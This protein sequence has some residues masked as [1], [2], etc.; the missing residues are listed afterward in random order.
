MITKISTYRLIKDVIETEHKL[1][2]GLIM[3]QDINNSKQHIQQ[4]FPF[5]C[6]EA[7]EISNNKIKI[8]VNNDNGE[9]DINII[10][11]FLLLTNN[12][13]YYIAR[14]KLISNSNINW[15]KMDL[16]KFKEKYYDSNFLKNIIR[17]N[18]LIEPKFD[19]KHK[20][21]TNIL[22]H[23]TENRYLDR[24]F[25]SGL[26]PKSKN[27]LLNYPERIYFVYHLED[28]NLYI[29]N[30]TRYYTFNIQKSKQPEKSKYQE[31]E[32]VILKIELPTNNDLIFYEDP[33]F[34]DKGIYTY[35]NINP[36]FININ[37]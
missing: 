16:S 18:F 31:I 17:Y 6:V 12:L 19:I 14:V 25:K 2:E 37:K 27:T 36:Q 26:I 24:I 30:K 20:L 3:T 35:D 23:V 34:I 22:Y 9:I 10:S 5:E 13:G 8:E 29:K 33:N 32:Y 1:N 4:I 7:V 11:K 21:K 28:A 15:Y